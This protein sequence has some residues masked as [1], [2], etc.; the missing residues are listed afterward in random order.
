MMLPDPA[1]AL[2][3]P[4]TVKYIAFMGHDSKFSVSTTTDLW[5]IDVSQYLTQLQTQ[6]ESQPLTADAAKN[7]TRPMDRP[8]GGAGSEIGFRGG[9]S[10][11]WQGDRL[12]FLMCDRGAG[13]IYQVV[14]GGDPGVTGG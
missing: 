1:T 3:G 10:I 12:V 2:S 14:P 4:G 9:A 13:G 6:G 7:I 5:I 11:T 8:V